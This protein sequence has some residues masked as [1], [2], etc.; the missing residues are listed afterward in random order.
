MPGDETNKSMINIIYRYGYATRAYNQN[1]FHV[2]IRVYT[3]EFDM[4]NSYLNLC[5]GV[6]LAKLVTVF[7]MTL[8]NVCIMFKADKIDKLVD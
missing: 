4:E 2:A 3:P 7:A 1:S 8:Y 6:D 5:N